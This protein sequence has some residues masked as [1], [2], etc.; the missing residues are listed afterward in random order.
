MELSS[1]L[2]FAG[3]W[4]GEVLLWTVACSAA[5]VGSVTVVSALDTFFAEAG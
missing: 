3:D 1:L 2:Q 4:I 5:V